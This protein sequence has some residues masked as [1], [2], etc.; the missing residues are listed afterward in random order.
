MYNSPRRKEISIDNGLIYPV[1]SIIVKF[2]FYLNIVEMFKKISDYLTLKYYQNHQEITQKIKI[3]RNRN[4]TIDL[5]IISK[6]ILIIA[7]MLMS[8]PSIWAQTLVWYLL[9]YNVLTY[10][11]YHLQPLSERA[12]KRDIFSAL[13]FSF[14]SSALIN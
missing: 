3:R 10:F 14:N 6:F 7:I 4:I 2:L 11:Y 1:F 5:F 8:I 9:F 13:R 12:S